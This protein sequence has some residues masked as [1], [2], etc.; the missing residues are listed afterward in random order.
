MARSRKR[1]SSQ[2]K[3]RFDWVYRGLATEGETWAESESLGLRSYGGPPSAANAGVA[4]AR[5]LI[6]YDSQNRLATLAGAGPLGGVGAGLLHRSARAEG[7]RPLIRATQGTI[8]FR[9]STWALGNV[10][11]WG[12]RLGAFEQDPN[13][14]LLSLD[15][16]YGMWTDAAGEP[17]WGDVNVFANEGRHVAERRYW[18]AFDSSKGS[19]SSFDIRWSGRRALSPEHAWALYFE[20]HSTSVNMVIQPWLR[21][22]VADEA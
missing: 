7:R 19:D 16:A 15:A 22:L 21:S 8:Y 2:P 9:A 18:R 1:R 17:F 5:A 14:G 11:A 4:N 20:V 3:R 6:L 12:W 13:T 10:M